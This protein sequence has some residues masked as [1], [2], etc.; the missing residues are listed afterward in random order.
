MPYCLTNVFLYDNRLYPLSNIHRF[1]IIQT[2]FDSTC[3]P[4]PD[5]ED[6]AA[7]NL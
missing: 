6:A 2:P 5:E 7:A 1:L 4:W 3:N